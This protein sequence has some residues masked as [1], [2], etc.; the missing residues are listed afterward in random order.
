[1]FNKDCRYE[2][3]ANIAVKQISRMR[4]KQPVRVSDVLNACP[5]CGV[6]IFLGVVKCR[7]CGQVIKWE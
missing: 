7:W 3:A 4:P 1:M 6:G 2:R 5:T